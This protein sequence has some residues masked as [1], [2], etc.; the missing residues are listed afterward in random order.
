MTNGSD[1]QFVD[2]DYSYVKAPVESRKIKSKESSFNHIS[3]RWRKFRL[4][5]EKEKL[6]QKKQELVDMKFSANQLAAESSQRAHTEAKVMKK[7]QSIARLEAKVKL[8]ETGR[9]TSEEFVDSRAI[10][11]KNM[12]MKNMIYKRDFLY[13]VNEETA[14]EIMGEDR[15][16]E[17]I[18]DEQTRKIGEKVKEIM[19]DQSVAEKAQQPVVERFTTITDAV[20][21]GFSKPDVAS[22][23]NA[24]SPKTEQAPTI[25]SAEDIQ[26]AIDEEMRKVRVS[27]NGSRAATTRKFNEDGTYRVSGKNDSNGLAEDG[28]YH[29]K[30]GDGTGVLLEVDE[31][32]TLETLSIE[33]FEEV[34]ERKKISLVGA[35]VKNMEELK[36]IIPGREMPV[37]VPERKV[38]EATKTINF[39][40]EQTATE[41]VEEVVSMPSK[42]NSQPSSLDALFA[43][44]AIL[45][46]EKQ[47]LA[48]RAASASEHAAEMD[49]RYLETVE[50]FN[51]YA[52]GLEKDCNERL[53]E[54]ENAL[55][56]AAAREEE[57]RAMFAVMGAEPEVKKDEPA[58]EEPRRVR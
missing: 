1:F 57:I 45:S 47:R 22:Y 48:A 10:K 36:N 51:A 40:P 33:P 41:E 44:V 11:L 49:A 6:L 17:E 23:M 13:G 39:V 55:T 38:E 20:N 24:T 9:Y 4:E 43:R 50:R 15:K 54:T 32:D 53:Q 56:L 7:T 46:K 28:T 18:V 8:L 26:T 3:S 19:A 29:Y 30:K 37:V 58:L 34:N 16:V 12:M 31:N 25:I 42:K 52:D 2:H 27:R 14:K 5:H 35:K 21:A